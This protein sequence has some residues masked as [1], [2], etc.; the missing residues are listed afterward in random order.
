MEEKTP[1]RIGNFLDMKET[2]LTI[3]I[4][5]DRLLLLVLIIFFNQS[6]QRDG[7]TSLGPSKWH[8]SGNIMEGDDAVTADN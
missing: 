7:A 4:S 1:R 6:L 8:F 5:R 2:L 3:I